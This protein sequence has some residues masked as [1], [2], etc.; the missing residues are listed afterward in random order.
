[1]MN[2]QQ[3]KLQTVNNWLSNAWVT[4]SSVLIQQAISLTGLTLTAQK[5]LHV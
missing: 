1:M 4:H 2:S 5:W 3:D